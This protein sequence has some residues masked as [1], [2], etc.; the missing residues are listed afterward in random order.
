MNIRTL[1][2]TL[3]VLFPAA[4]ANAQS[5]SQ[6]AVRNLS[7]I[8][9]GH[10]ASNNAD[11]VYEAMVPKVKK[12]YTRDELVAPLALMRAAYGKLVS[13]KFKAIQPGQR[14]VAGEWLRTVTYW[15]PVV[16]EKYPTGLFLKVEITSEGGRFYL[17]GYSVIQFLGNKA[18]PF[19][20]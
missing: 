16:T 9:A 13:Y 20:E 11:A 4:L 18:P 10:V 6:D 5:P 14:L 17:A 1:V 3:L 2:A 15:Y 8:V 7:D 19:L 12:V